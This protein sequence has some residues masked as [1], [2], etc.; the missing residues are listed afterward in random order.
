MGL[1]AQVSAPAG[2]FALAARF[3]IGFVL[4]GAALPKVLAS[5]DFER[6]VAGYELLNPRAA[7]LVARSVP[8]LEA[9]TAVGLLVGI[10]VEALCFV[11]SGLLLVFAAAMA[12][13]LF[14]GREID[15]GCGS[16]AAPRRISWSIVG[17]DIGLSAAAIAA[18]LIHPDVLVVRS[19]AGEV[20]AS[21]LTS[22]T[23]TVILTTSALALLARAL[24]LAAWEM[25]RQAASLVN[26]VDGAQP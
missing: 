18:A 25:R 5:R 15:C 2:G 6:A 8:L 4:L 9:V 17:A 12:I 26:T 11:A 20:A 3:L 7:R 14:R 21:G 16:K 23:G 22:S 1:L 10:L 24:A 13:N 19:I